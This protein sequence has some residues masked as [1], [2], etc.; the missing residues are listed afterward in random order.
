MAERSSLSIESCRARRHSA[1]IELSRIE[2][3][4]FAR[5]SSSRVEYLVL[6][7]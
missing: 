3:S 5:S 6:I 4:F 1:R 2:K 7:E